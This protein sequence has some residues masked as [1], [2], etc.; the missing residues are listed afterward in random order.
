M[1]PGT[2]K[3]VMQNWDDMNRKISPRVWKF[4]PLAIMRVIWKEINRRAF[5]GVE[6]GFVELQNSLLSQVS[7]WCIHDVS[8]CIDDLAIFWCRFSFSS[9]L[10]AY[11]VSPSINIIICQS[12][13]L[14]IHK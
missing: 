11:G 7:F 3:E 6:L 10:L 5:E 9:I 2:V 8:I 13:K 12:K 4:V 1:M 14:S